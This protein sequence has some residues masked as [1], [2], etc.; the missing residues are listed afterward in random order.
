MD[1]ARFNKFVNQLVKCISE[2]EPVIINFFLLHDP[3]SRYDG[4][5]NTF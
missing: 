3:C 2:N 1:D 4:Q 5:L